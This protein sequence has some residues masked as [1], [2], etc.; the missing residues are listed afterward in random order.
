MYRSVTDMRFYNI[1][2]K[3]Y[4]KRVSFSSSKRSD[5]SKDNGVPGPTRYNTGTLSDKRLLV[6]FKAGREV[7]LMIYVGV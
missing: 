3:K 6:Q 7:I 5:L 4:N 1:E 2:V